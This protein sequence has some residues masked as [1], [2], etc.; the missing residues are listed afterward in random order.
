M[1]TLKFLKPLG[2][3]VANTPSARGYAGIQFL[4]THK[5]DHNPLLLRLVSC[6]LPGEDKVL[7]RSLNHSGENYFSKGFN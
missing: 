2:W 6:G 5:L 3:N 7:E 1:L 4:R